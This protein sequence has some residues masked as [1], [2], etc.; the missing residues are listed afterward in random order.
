MSQ[1]D[2]LEKDG[3]PENGL[4]NYED[5]MKAFSYGETLE[6]SV[7]TAPVNISKSTDSNVHFVQLQVPGFNADEISVDIK[8]DEAGYK[9][10]VEGSFAPGDVEMEEAGC[11]YTHKTFEVAPF[12]TVV[13]INREIAEGK[14][15][16]GLDKGVLTIQCTPNADASVI[17][18][19]Y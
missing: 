14:F 10:V 9:L 5:L 19:I 2:L 4:Y 6:K 11:D 18:K 17:K 1:R 16:V 7:A 15:N 12:K 8:N 3:G 13:K